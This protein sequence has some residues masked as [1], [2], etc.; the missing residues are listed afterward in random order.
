MAILSGLLEAK[1]MMRTAVGMG[2]DV[3][4]LVTGKP[5]WLG[6]IE[7]PHSHGL[8]GNSDADVA[9]HALTDAILGALGDGDIGAQFP[10]RASEWRGA[11]TCRLL[12]FAGKRVTAAGGDRKTVL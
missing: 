12:A 2:Y 4:R 7:I 10:P 6:G 11:G 1:A 3:H 5:L 8:E 9:P